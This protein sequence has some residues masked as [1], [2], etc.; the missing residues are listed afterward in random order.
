MTEP[1]LA[2]DRPAAADWTGV[3]LVALAALCFSASI[4]FVRALPAFDAPTLTF[5][6][7]LFAFLFFCLLTP[8]AAR[9]REPLRVRAYHAHVPVLIGLGLVMAATAT[10]YTY[11]IQHTTAANAALLV[12]SAPLYVALLAPWLLKEA[13]PRYTWA[14]L[15]LAIL[16]IVLIAGPGGLRLDAA[17]LG[18]LAAGVLSGVGYA[19]PM[20]IGRHLGG[21]V[22]GLTQIWWG[23][24]VAALVLL[25]FALRGDV[26]AALANFPTLAALGVI[27]MGLSYLLI[28]LGLRRVRAQ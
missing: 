3:A 7:A 24:G 27:S 28:F 13:R 23:S 21:R 4:I 17:E 8:F 16:G 15:A 14:S 11:A 19:M 20:L 12:N 2:P 5:Y 10:L 18:G 22:S 1:S 25:P 9:F 6:R 26:G